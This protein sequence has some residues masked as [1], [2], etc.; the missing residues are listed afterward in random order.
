MSAKLVLR[1]EW[2][3]TVRTCRD[4]FDTK[5]FSNLSPEILVQWIAPY[6]FRG[7]FSCQTSRVFPS[8]QLDSYSLPAWLANHAAGSGS[9]SLI[10]ELAIIISNGDTHGWWGFWG[11]S[12]GVYFSILKLSTA[13]FR[14]L[15]L[16]FSPLLKYTRSPSWS[17]CVTE[18]HRSRKKTYIWV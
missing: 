15:K 18:P 1:V 5:K 17:G 4:P 6:G 11:F 13:T 10:T 16:E 12:T 9:S 7:D 14:R 2:N 8:G 3:E